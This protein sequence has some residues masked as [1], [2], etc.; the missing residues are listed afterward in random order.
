MSVV[1]PAAP[2]SYEGMT[3]VP[4]IQQ[5]VSPPSGF[6]QAPIGSIWVNTTAQDAFIQLH[7]G[8]WP[9]IVSQTGNIQ[10]FI[11]DSGTSPVLPL[12]GVVT[13]A[14]NASTGTLTVG[15]TNTLTFETTFAEYTTSPDILTL[16][17]PGANTTPV[18]TFDASG[19]ITVPTGYLHVQNTAPQVSITNTTLSGSTASAR[20]TIQSGNSSAQYGDCYIG[21]F[22]GAQATSFEY[23]LQ[24]STGNLIWQITPANSNPNMD[25]TTTMSLDTSGNL[26]LGNNTTGGTLL[27]SYA[28]GTMSP[29]IKCYNSH[30]ASGNNGALIWSHSAGAGHGGFFCSSIDNG[31]GSAAYYSFGVAAGGG[32]PF[33]I[34]YSATVPQS[35]ESSLVSLSINS[36][37][38]VTFPT[39]LAVGASGPTVTS[40]SGAPGGSAPQGSLYLRTDGSGINNRA[41][42]NTNGTTGWTAIVTVA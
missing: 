24:K 5:T 22:S 29:T 40:G 13:M 26:T 28:S 32:N 38:L 27:V 11:P 8:V 41:Y 33:N 12:A 14:G 16:F 7:P 9:S 39:F 18:M 17:N 1:L 4:Y 30:N 3:S 21:F 31:S 25:G 36:S 19:N 10:K 35:P 37:G 2:L 15:G 23:G 34:S 6:K 42:I 20:M